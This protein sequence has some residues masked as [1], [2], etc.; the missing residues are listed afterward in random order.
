MLAKPRLFWQV[1]QRTEDWLWFSVWLTV[2]PWSIISS[3]CWHP[4]RA[5]P[6]PRSFLC[7]VS[8]P[9]IVGFRL[10]AFHSPIG[11]FFHPQEWFCL[12]RKRSSLHPDGAVPSLTLAIQ[13]L[14]TPHLYC[15]SPI[16]SS[17]IFPVFVS[18]KYLDLRGFFSFLACLSA[19]GML[20]GLALLE[21][22]TDILSLICPQLESR[23]PKPWQSKRVLTISYL[24]VSQL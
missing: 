1:L 15:V 24:N 4:I 5:A 19:L 21:C 8:E 9:N 2:A 20:P 6:L 14:H 7:C 17:H 13:R 3:V 18:R 12:P 11:W 23:L 22:L 16:P 10:C